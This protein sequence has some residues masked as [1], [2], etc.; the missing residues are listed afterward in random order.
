MPS[1]QNEVV[2]ASLSPVPSSTSTTR[3]RSRTSGVSPPTASAC[4]G[5]TV[6]T[7]QMPSI[8]DTSSI[9][10]TSRQVSAA[11]Q[12]GTRQPPSAAS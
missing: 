4:G 2:T 12:V 11:R 6:G 5:I 7:F 8:R 1:S 3:R 10:S 9:R